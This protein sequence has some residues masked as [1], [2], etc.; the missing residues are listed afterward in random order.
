MN[1][2]L[3]ISN[4]IMTNI[5]NK[6][7]INLKEKIDKVIYK[8]NKYF[9]KKNVKEILVYVSKRKHL[10]RYI[11]DYYNRLYKYEKY[12]I[13]KNDL[14]EFIEF[15]F[16]DQYFV[17]M[18]KL[19]KDNLIEKMNDYKYFCNKILN[20]LPYEALKNRFMNYRGLYYPT[21]NGI[22]F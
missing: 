1:Y 11:K 21:V 17:F 9:F 16:Q 19:F 12:K 4:I 15:Y 3:Y 20:N 18:N 22:G 2:K 8:N 5:Y 10:I 13:L 6:L 7:N 14:L